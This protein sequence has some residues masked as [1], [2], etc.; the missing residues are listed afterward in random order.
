VDTLN[1]I[2]PD[3]EVD[4]AGVDASTVASDPALRAAQL[5]LNKKKKQAAIKP[6]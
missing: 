4:E 2:D 1:K 3:I 6:N 5:K